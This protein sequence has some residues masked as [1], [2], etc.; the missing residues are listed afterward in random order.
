MTRALLH[1][2]SGAMDSATENFVR[3]RRH[4]DL[5]ALGLVFDALAPRLLALALHLCGNAADAEDALQATFVVAM[6]KAVTFD[7]S[8]PVGPWLAGE[9]GRAHV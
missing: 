7:A 4:G 1:D 2:D 8:Q 5:A 9:I 6:R 3:Y